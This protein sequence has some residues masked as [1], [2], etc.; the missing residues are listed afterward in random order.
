MKDCEEREGKERLGEK[1]TTYWIADIGAFDQTRAKKQ[2]IIFYRI[3]ACSFFLSESSTHVVDLRNKGEMTTH[4]G[5]QNRSLQHFAERR[6][7]AAKMA[8]A[9]AEKVIKVVTPQH[10]NQSDRMEVLQ[11]RFVVVDLSERSSCVDLRGKSVVSV[12]ADG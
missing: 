4:I 12:E 11:N 7:L 5:R 1:A 10:M 9:A 8:K 3:L 2:T 6:S